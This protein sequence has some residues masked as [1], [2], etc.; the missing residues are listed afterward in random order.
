MRAQDGHLLHTPTPHVYLK[1]PFLT[2][3]HDYINDQS[4]ISTHLLTE[5]MDPIC[6]QGIQLVCLMDSRAFCT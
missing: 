2:T 3:S 6:G 1:T 5:P 4:D